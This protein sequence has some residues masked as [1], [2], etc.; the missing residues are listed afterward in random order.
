MKVSV[1]L[2]L[3]AS[4]SAITL[5]KVVVD[6][7]NWPGVVLAGDHAIM[8]KA[9]SPVDD[10]FNPMFNKF[11]YGGTL[12]QERHNVRQELSSRLRNALVQEN[13]MVPGDLSMLQIEGREICETVEC[14]RQ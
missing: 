13:D 9:S 12:A 7:H 14:A 6:R 8:P 11:R 4:T 5:T 2:A 1:L 10:D 3:V